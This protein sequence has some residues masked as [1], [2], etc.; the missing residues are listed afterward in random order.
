MAKAGN[1]MC[2]RT[3]TLR[4]LELSF[5]WSQEV[6]EST[7]LQRSCPILCQVMP[8]RGGGLVANGSPRLGRQ[9]SDC[10]RLRGP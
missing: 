7:I 10:G 4:I 2:L 1:S 6:P 8:E 9:V 3:S 5:I